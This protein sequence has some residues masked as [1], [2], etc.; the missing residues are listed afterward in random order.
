MGS[1]T[2]KALGTTQNG[3]NRN[4]VD[5]SS[6]KA[7]DDVVTISS[8]TQ[9]LTLGGSTSGGWS[10]YTGSGYLYAA[11]SNSNYLRTQTS[12]DKNGLADIT[13]TN[14]VA[15]IVFKGSNT[16][17]TLKYNSDNKLFSCYSTGQ[18]DVYLY[19]AKESSSEPAA[20]V[21]STGLY[22]IKDAVGY[23][24]VNTDGTLTKTPKGDGLGNIFVVKAQSDGTYTLEAQG[25]TIS[26]FSGTTIGLST[27]E[28]TVTLEHGTLNDYI[29]V[30]NETYVNADVKA[31]AVGAEWTFEEITT[32]NAAT[33]APT[34]ALN[35]PTVNNVPDGD[36]QFTTFYA[37]FPYTVSGTN[38]TVYTVN[39]KRV[40]VEVPSART[41]P[42][43]TAVVI[44]AE[45]GS[46]SIVPKYDAL[47]A[48][49]P[50][51][52]ADNILQGSYEPISVSSL[53]T[54]KRVLVFNGHNNTPGF[55][56]YSG[57]TLAANKA[58][59]VIDK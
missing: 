29:K 48:T 34:I 16:R 25:K 27:E 45:E 43:G 20:S 51:A 40:F 26:G 18:K 8:D 23:L 30:G 11:S 37:D 9:V 31:N 56:P 59:I 22:R 4:A 36:L 35:Q 14:N 13:F 57:N 6:G 44:A 15:S 24:C 54:G 53:G 7:G 39:R 52:N 38:V 28:Q 55:Y 21:I 2:S 32:S 17:N 3:N 41:L 50:E 58:Y 5:V 49:L 33:N 19:V 12:N 10:F 47:S 46:V 1:G 42:A